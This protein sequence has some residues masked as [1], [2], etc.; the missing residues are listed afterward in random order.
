MGFSPDG[1]ES[2]GYRRVVEHPVDQ[3]EKTQAIPRVAADDRETRTFQRPGSTTVQPKVTVREKQQKPVREPYKP[4]RI[5]RA[6]GN[7]L[8][9]LLAGFCLAIISITFA[10]ILVKY[11]GHLFQ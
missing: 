9:I 11:Y 8:A 4:G 5:M 1:P 6:F 7:G 2:Y 3:R 10:F